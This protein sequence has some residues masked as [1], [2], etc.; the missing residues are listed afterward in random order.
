MC[1]WREGGR[2]GVVEGGREGETWTSKS[3]IF[4]SS[5]ARSDT[6]K[7]RVATSRIIVCNSFLTI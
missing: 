7:L 1:V 6:H 5:L 2:E 4:A 3:V